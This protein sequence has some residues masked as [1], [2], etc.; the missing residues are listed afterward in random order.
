[1]AKAEYSL[2]LRSI[3]RLVEDERVRQLSDQHLLRQFSDHRDE[4][5]FAMLLRR[6]GPM[7]YGIRFPNV[8]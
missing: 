2:I 6:H 8:K 5:A 1:M 3:R 7:V 4:A